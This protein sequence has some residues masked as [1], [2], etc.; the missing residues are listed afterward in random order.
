MST[1]HQSPQSSLPP[2][3]LKTI[4]TT[5]WGTGGNTCTITDPYIH[6]NS[7][8]DVW[9]TGATPQAGQWA[10]AITQGQVV[11]TSSSSEASSLPISYIIL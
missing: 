1:S 4:S 2:L 8:F 3:A 6:T 7:C 5:T 11:I 9:V 10:L